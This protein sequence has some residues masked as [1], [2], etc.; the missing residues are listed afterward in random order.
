[1]QMQSYRSWQDYAEMAM[2]M[3]SSYMGEQRR[4]RYTRRSYAERY[5]EDMFDNGNY[6]RCGLRS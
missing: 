5:A 2:N 1:M 3:D 6:K 4:Q